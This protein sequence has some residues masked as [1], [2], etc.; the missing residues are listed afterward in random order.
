MKLLFFVLGLFISGSLMAQSTGSVVV[1]KDPRVD[2]LLKKQAE[3]NN[4]S[5]RNSSKR[6]FA[7]GYRV[8][9]ANTTN[10]N[11]AMAART[12]I[13]TY[14]PELKPY[15]HHQSPYFRITAGN[16]LTRAEAVAYQKRMSNIFPN[17]VFI[18]NATVEVKP[19]EVENKE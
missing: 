18:V 1:H 9:V 2:V 3:V 11:E 15:L 4:L 17:G 16:F 19:E 6:R 5:T 8:M 10:R 7:K 13:L 14:Y 12:K